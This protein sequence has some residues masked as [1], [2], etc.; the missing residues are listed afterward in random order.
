MTGPIA[1]EGAR[2]GD[3]LEV[4]I[5]N[6]EPRLR[7]GTNIAAW[8]GY[9]YDQFRKER[10]TIYTFDVASRH[11]RALFAFDYT[12]SELYSLP[13]IVIPPES[14]LR[15]PALRDV[16]VPLRPH[17]GVMGVAPP[18]SGRV[19][20]IP[21]GPF[22]GN[23]DNWR[24]GPGATM[25]YPIFVDEAL[26]FVGDPHMA[27]GDG[28]LSGTAIEASANV[29]LQLIVRQDLPLRSPL[30]ETETHWYTHGFDTRPLPLSG[31]SS[32]AEVGFP[33]AGDLNAAM[34]LAALEMLNFLTHQRGLSADEAY[35]LLSVAADFG[36]TQVV[37]M[38]QGVHCGLPRSVFVPR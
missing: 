9:L 6:I 14:T 34:R 4:R 13:G 2:A 33:P 10:I 7:F 35:S 31:P 18:Q 38:R 16:V 12:A 30:L 25:Y 28:E 5:L 32:P 1:D 8:W 15:E 20:S 24:L 3:T 17:V 11:A 29:W 19:N 37:D 21:P 22:G 36:I 26:F 23:L 27:E